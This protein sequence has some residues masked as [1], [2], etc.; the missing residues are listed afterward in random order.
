MKRDYSKTHNMTEMQ[1]K[2]VAHARGLMRAAGKELIYT[3]KYY[4]DTRT[5]KCYSNGVDV[6]RFKED[7]AVYAQEVGAKNITVK[8]IKSPWWMRSDMKSLIVRVPAD[9]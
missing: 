3:N 9:C 6:E 1:K 4:N 8:V 5:V 2:V 7:V